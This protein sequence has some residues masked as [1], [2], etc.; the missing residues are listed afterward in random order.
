MLCWKPNKLSFYITGVVYSVVGK[1]HSSGLRPK[2]SCAD[3]TWFTKTMPLH[4]FPR[5][6]RNPCG[7]KGGGGSIS[8]ERTKHLMELSPLPQEPVC[9]F[10]L[11]WHFDAEIPRRDPWIGSARNW[12]IGWERH[13]LESHKTTRGPVLWMVT[14]CGCMS[15]R[16]VKL[17]I[18]GF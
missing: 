11:L 18:C 16:E 1:T 10:S 5:Q 4:R 9:T 15:G 13:E 3:S 12:R 7:K 17:L 14:K 6:S 2:R 8:D